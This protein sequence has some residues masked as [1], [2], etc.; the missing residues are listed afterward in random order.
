[1]VLQAQT[2][3][4]RALA[5][6]ASGEIRSV[7]TPQHDCERYSDKVRQ[8]IGRTM[9]IIGRTPRGAA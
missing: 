2:G 7:K 6:S 1:L 8:G 3:I 9:T 4:L 5:A